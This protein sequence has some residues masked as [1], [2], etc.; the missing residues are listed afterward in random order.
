[1]RLIQRLN[2]LV[3]CVSVLYNW[4]AMALRPAISNLFSKKIMRKNAISRVF[5]GFLSLPGALHRITSQSREISLNM[6]AVRFSRTF[7][8][9]PNKMKFSFFFCSSFLFFLV[10]TDIIW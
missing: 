3:V 10:L 4:L 8:C 7:Y 1:M 5:S 2:Y 6:V 9:S